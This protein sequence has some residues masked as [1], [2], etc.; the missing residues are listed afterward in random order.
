M[1]INYLLADMTREELEQVEQIIKTRK[2]E[3]E[4][5]ELYDKYKNLQD[6][7]EQL[8]NEFTDL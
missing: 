8:L 7:Y 5:D 3:I 4:Y 6:K 1:N 2:L